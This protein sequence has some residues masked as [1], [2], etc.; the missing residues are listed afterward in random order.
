M[1]AYE[2]PTA[3]FKTDGDLPA[4][5]VRVVLLS[6]DAERAW[7]AEEASRVTLR[8]LPGQWRTAG[9]WLEATLDTPESRAHCAVWG[10]A[11]LGCAADV[12]L[13][14]SEPLRQQFSARLL[15]TAKKDAPGPERLCAE[16]LGWIASTRT[17]EEYLA[18]WLAW[19]QIAPATEL[20]QWVLEGR[21]DLPAA[22]MQGDALSLAG[23]RVGLRVD[24][25]DWQEFLKSDRWDRVAA[26]WRMASVLGDPAPAGSRAPVEI[27]SAQTS[28]FL[29]RIAP[30]AAP[31]LQ[32]AAILVAEEKDRASAEL[33]TA[34]R[35]AAEALLHAVLQARPLTRDRFLLNAPLDFPFGLR[36]A[37][38][39]L[40]ATEARL[41][42]EIDGYYHFR[43]ADGYRR[44]RRKDAAMQEHG[45]FVLRFLAE[46]AV[47][48]LE[49]VIARIEAHL[50][51]RD[52]ASR[53]SAAVHRL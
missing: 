41:V 11:R 48:D 26:R 34:A 35:S 30:A 27:P 6:A 46:D 7:L 50:A 13:S 49:N 1:K 53:P 38:G 33:S 52:L 42:V 2:E 4:G 39:D 10:A 44:D 25:A 40:V 15:A 43:D 37:E 9:E 3:A 16:V 23:L 51:R 19:V 20:P 18:R 14:V 28:D 21:A 22:L 47:C 29:H 36:A 32:R 8:L 17:D 24:L 31:L 5:G 45:W 12:L